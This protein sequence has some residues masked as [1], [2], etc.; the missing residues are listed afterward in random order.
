MTT[1]RPALFVSL[2][3]AP[4]ASAFQNLSQCAICDGSNAGN[5]VI[6]ISPDGCTCPGRVCLDH[7][8]VL[9]L[10]HSPQPS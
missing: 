2:L 9:T 8:D 3:F 10:S 1:I 6:Q 5:V 7:V 4:L